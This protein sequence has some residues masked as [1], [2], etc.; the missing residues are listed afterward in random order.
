MFDEI[1]TVGEQK[2]SH[3]DNLASSALPQGIQMVIELDFNWN[4]FSKLIFNPVLKY[5]N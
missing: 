2:N 3:G 5:T 1:W 4:S